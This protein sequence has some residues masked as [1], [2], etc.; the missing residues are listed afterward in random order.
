MSNSFAIE[1]GEKINVGAFI[2]KVGMT[3]FGIGQ[4]ALV[5]LC[6]ML[7]GFTYMLVPYTMAFIAQDWELSSLA[8]G[9]LSSWASLG[10]IFGGFLGGLMADKIGRRK[11][12]LITVLVYTFFTAA[13]FFA[14]N[15]AVFIVF[16]FITGL[17]I[18]SSAALTTATSAENATTK[19]RTLVVGIVCGATPFGYVAAS[20]VAM[21]VVPADG[22][23]AVFL[24]ALVGLLVFFLL[25]PTLKET[26]FWALQKGREKEACAY[27]N[28][29]KKSAGVTGPE[30]TADM[31]EVPPV[32]KEQRKKSSY[33]EL[34]SSSKLA[35][36]TI[37]AALIY[38]SA[39]CTLY[40]VNTWYPTLMLD[41]GLEI[42]EAYGFSLAM[43]A[44]GV[45]GNIAAGFLL[46]AIGRRKGE[47][48]GFAASFVFIIFMAICTG[49]GAMITAAML[50]G[51]AINY[52]PSS[53]NAVT[54]ELFPTSA[55]AS[56]VAFVMST[57]RI[58]GFLSP[59]I[60]GALLGMG[61]TSSGLMICFAIPCLVGILFVLIFMKV[62]NSSK[63]LEDVE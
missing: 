54:P 41:N 3:G 37:G 38:F 20:L 1:K 32:V 19:R 46:Q 8:T 29:L 39:M 58:A 7:E 33:R 22:W 59:I 16:R 27:M 30:I 56:G 13:V 42:Q 23:R 9:S 50:V 48:V 2:D 15:F 12:L 25:L 10:C 36:I 47:V 52:L 11:S 44:M 26:P 40:G 4:I 43:N 61:L 24:F 5:T 21:F 28:A 34:F 55:R 31:L 63:S 14:P 35:I 60:A 51:L 53:V 45:V 57:G 49:P 62:N 6:S 17:A 18:G